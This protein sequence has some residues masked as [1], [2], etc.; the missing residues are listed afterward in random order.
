MNENSPDKAIRDDLPTEGRAESFWFV[1]AKGVVRR[2][3]IRS[4]PRLYVAGTTGLLVY[5]LFSGSTGQT[6]AFLIAFDG[7]ALTFLAAV[8]IMMARATH[9]DMQRRAELEDEGRYTVLC[10][11]SVAA[12]AVLLAIV[13]ELHGSKNAA[14]PGPHIALAAATIL[15]SWFFMNTIFA[16]HYAHGYYGD[17]DPSDQYKPVGGL[18]FP[19]EKRPDY[20]DFMYFAFCI[21]MTFQVSDVEI[22]DYEIRRVALAHSVL[23]F[24]F[25]VV[26]LALTINIVAGLI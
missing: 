5:L 21:G 4:H 25:N 10:F 7:G 2:T 8:W 15:L 17:A 11:S 1:L 9:D 23:G 6:A 14:S 12:I 20:W 26:V 16:L 18:N 13:F 3:L 19:G 22:E 24:F